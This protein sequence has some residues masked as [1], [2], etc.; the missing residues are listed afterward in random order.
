MSI[1][2]LNKLGN[3][4]V[5]AFFTPEPK[6][7]CIEITGR[8]QLR[9]KHCFNNSGLGNNQEL[10]LSLIERLLDEMIKWDVQVL[11]ISGGEPTM[12]HQFESIVDACARHNMPISMNSHGVYTKRVLER[13][14]KAPIERFLISIDG[15]QG[16]NDAIRGKG[17]YERA[18]H[19]CKILKKTG[20]AVTIAYHVGNNN[21]Q[22]LGDLID[23]AA[24]IDIDFK[25]S[26]I[27]PIG[28]AIKEL[29]HSFVSSEDYY[30][31]V[32][33][34]SEKRA[35]YPHI[36]ISTDFDI[37]DNNDE[38]RELNPNL[39]SCDAGRKMI[40][41]SYSGDI[42]PCAFFATPEKTFSAGNI[43]HDSVISTWRNA[44]VFLPFRVQQK[45]S[46][47]QLTR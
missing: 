40:S 33:I 21:I 7:I 39:A 14:T 41:I 47:C 34:V 46:K 20:Q 36:K 23:I 25:V 19:S 6:D 30:N 28:R 12:H 2:W 16:A 5:Q 10:P 29:P 13:L 44:S 45:S 43:Y 35:R 32:Q 42:Y 3:S 27:R 1:N 24:S 15:L 9:C 22:D 18:M 31:V 26:P 37:L 4:S 11:R 17:T 8:C 38:K